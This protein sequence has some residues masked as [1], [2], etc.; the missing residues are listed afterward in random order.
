MLHLR[1]MLKDLLAHHK[2]V[3]FASIFA[4]FCGMLVIYFVRISVNTSSELKTASIRAQQSEQKLA[5]ITAELTLLKNQDQVKINQKNTEELSSINKLYKSVISSYESINTLRIQKSKT[6]EMDKLYA[7]VLSQLAEKNL[8]SAEASLSELDAKIRVANDKIAASAALQTDGGLSTANIPVNN[9]A[10]GSGYSRQSVKA[11]IGTFVVDIIAADMGSTRVLVDTASDSDCRDNCPVLSL[12]D[13]VGRTG[14]FAGIN[15]SYFCPASYPQ[16]AG[17]TNSYDTLAM[18][19]KKTYFNSDNNL[20]STVPAVIFLGGSMRFVG[21]SSGWGRDSSP[22]GVL[23]NQPLVLSG[24]NVVFGGDGDPKKG[25]KGNRSFVGNKG[26]TAYIGVVHNA[27]V[28][29][30]GHVLKALGLEN[31]LNL[32]SGGSTSLWSGGYKLGPGRNIP[33]AILF[34]R[35]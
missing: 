7:K 12:S 28:A 4:V 17:K 21:Q 20:Y 1:L 27:T 2:Y 13:Y 33:N 3:I 6:D 32:D 25:S 23:A 35:K 24:G 9:S 5:S 10:P 15:G 34:V 31:A 30:V 8:A 14:A 26:S 16:C 19:H 22:D 18:N 11:E 29:E